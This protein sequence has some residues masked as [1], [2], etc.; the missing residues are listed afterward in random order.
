MYKTYFS[1]THKNGQTKDTGQRKSYRAQTGFDTISSSALC[2]DSASAMAGVSA[3]P[4]SR[5]A[6]EVEGGLHLSEEMAG[7]LRL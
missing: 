4:S 6:R 1:D 7:S 5:K 3:R 2:A